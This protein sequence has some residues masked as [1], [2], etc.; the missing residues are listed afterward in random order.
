MQA[1]SG[2]ASGGDDA[3]ELTGEA[4]EKDSRSAD[5]HTGKNIRSPSAKP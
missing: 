4:K 3:C 2:G 5:G 1:H